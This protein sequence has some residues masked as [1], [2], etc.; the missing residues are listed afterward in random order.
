MWEENVGIDQCSEK[1]EKKE[2]FIFIKP[3]F[4]WFCYKLV[5]VHDWIGKT[6]QVIY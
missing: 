3:F 5:A 2:P 1:T 4:Y 6:K